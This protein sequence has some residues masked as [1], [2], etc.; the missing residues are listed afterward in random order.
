MCDP[1]IRAWKTL[2][3]Y[4]NIYIF[5]L[6]QTAMTKKCN[7]CGISKP[8]EE[9]HREGSHRRIGK[10]KQCKKEFYRENRTRLLQQSNAWAKRQLDAIDRNDMTHPLTAKLLTYR[11]Y[12]NAKARAKSSGAPFDLTVPDI[13]LPTHC[14]ILDIPLRMNEGTMQDDSPT[15]DRRIPSLGYVKSNVSVI[16]NRANRLKADG[17]L[18]EFQK[19]CNYLS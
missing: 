16:S 10:C 4:C 7:T 6:I 9:F 5:T 14:P 17:S 13:I 15:L 2:K 1:K 8:M 11:L 19:I 18:E 12:A 3:N